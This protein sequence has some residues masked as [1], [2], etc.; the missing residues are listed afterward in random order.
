MFGMI[1]ANLLLPIFARMLKQKSTDLEALLNQSR[2]LLVVTGSILKEVEDQLKLVY[3]FEKNNPAFFDKI[4]V[5]SHPIIPVNNIMEDLGSL[6]KIEIT[7]LK[8]SQLWD[9]SSI[10]FT[11][12]STSVGLEAY[13]LGLPL[14]VSAPVDNFNLSALFGMNNVF[15][16]NTFAEFSES[17]EH[18]LNKIELNNFNPSD[19]FCIDNNLNI[20]KS[21]LGPS[22]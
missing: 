13:Y 2:N 7:E 3:E 1:F 4:I 11:A 14:I 15:F 12:N 6:S 18:L 5:K 22:M 21:L 19:V 8:L 10:V 17:V 20:W 9:C 16:V